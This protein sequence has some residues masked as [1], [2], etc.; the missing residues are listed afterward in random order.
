M[1]LIDADALEDVA[2]EY[3][4]RHANG[5]QLTRSEYKLI[6]NFLF[7]YP[8]VD[9]VPVVRCKDC[10]LWSKNKPI[11]GS[12]M[13]ECKAHGGYFLPEDYCSDGER[14]ESE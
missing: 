6:D 10:K 12:D 8:T 1:R 2:A 14:R 5:L 7:E 3:Q 9:A 11:Y 13:C 4:E